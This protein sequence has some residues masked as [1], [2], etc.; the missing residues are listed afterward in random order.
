MKK[1]LLLNQYLVNKIKYL[2]KKAFKMKLEV[3]AKAN[4][5][6]HLFNK[7]K[8]KFDFIFL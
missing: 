8:N 5:N 4:L 7:H 3:D 1:F 2:F 6:K